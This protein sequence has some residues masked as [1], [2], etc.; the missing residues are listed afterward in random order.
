M[1]SLARCKELLGS[2]QVSD[3]QLEQLRGQFYAL[4]QA[5][6]A[7]N[8]ENQLPIH[9]ALAE[10]S[11][12]EPEEVQERAAILEYDAKLPRALAEYQ[13]L[14]MARRHRRQ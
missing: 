9:G 11:N 6:I 3:C 10:G 7:S 4:A 13:A 12:G 5:A 14:A 1:L 2:I 8:L